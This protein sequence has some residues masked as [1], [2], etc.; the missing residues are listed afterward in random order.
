MTK[1]II[2]FWIP[3][4]LLCCYKPHWH[5]A[6]MKKVFCHPKSFFFFS[7]SRFK[8]KHENNKNPGTLNNS[9]ID[10]DKILYMDQDCSMF[11]KEQQR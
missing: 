8:Q 9:N 2:P 6:H 5:C 11:L 1:I 10:F 3:P 4:K 7:V